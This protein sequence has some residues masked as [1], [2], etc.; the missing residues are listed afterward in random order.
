MLERVG[1]SP[2]TIL[3]PAAKPSMTRLT[4]HPPFQLAPPPSSPPKTSSP[5]K[6]TVAEKP[7]QP[8][9]QV[10]LHLEQQRQEIDRL[11][12]QAARGKCFSPAELLGLQAKVYAYSQNM[13]VI[14]HLV[15]RTVSAVK[16]T[17][18]TQV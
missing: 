16:T 10:V 6:P 3:T 12:E 1:Q 5:A 2:Q 18:N 15:D 14:S 11:V 17:M 8:L 13:E 9:R 4:P 7:T